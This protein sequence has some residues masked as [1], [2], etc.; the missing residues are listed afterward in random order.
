MLDAILSNTL[1]VDVPC[2]IEIV[3]LHIYS[4]VYKC[5]MVVSL[6]ILLLNTDG[7]EVICLSMILVI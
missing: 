2:D 3:L 7:D 1:M 5:L 6:S 4:N